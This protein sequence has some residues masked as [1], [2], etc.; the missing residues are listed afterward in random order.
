MTYLDAE[1]VLLA[2]G[3]HLQ[4][5]QPTVWLPFTTCNPPAKRAAK[6]PAKGA[7]HPNSKF[8]QKEA[9]EELGAFGEGS[10]RLPTLFPLCRQIARWEAGFCLRLCTELHAYP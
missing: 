4:L 2:P 9:F 3:N 6:G 10:R 7:A 8:N 5:S 1:N